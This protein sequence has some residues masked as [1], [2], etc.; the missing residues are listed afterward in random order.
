MHRVH[1]LRDKHPEAAA[2]RAK[3]L[4]AADVQKRKQ[5]MRVQLLQKEIE[6]LPDSVFNILPE[7]EREQPKTPT[8]KKKKPLPG[9]ASDRRSSRGSSQSSSKSHRSREQLRSL[10]TSP[11][12]GMGFPTPTPRSNSVSPGSSPGSTRSHPSSTHTPS[13]V[14]E[15]PGAKLPSPP[16]IAVP[17]P[18]RTAPPLPSPKLP[19]TPTSS[20]AS[21]QATS[22]STSPGQAVRSPSMNLK[23]RRRNRDSRNRTGNPLTTASNVRRTVS[24][25]TS[26]PS[27]NIS[28]VAPSSTSSGGSYQF[29]TVE[30]GTRNRQTR[31]LPTT[32]PPIRGK[33]REMRLSKSTPTANLAFRDDE[34]SDSDVDSI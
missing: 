21:S 23:E 20:K 10:S 32:T 30:T 17:K 18:T 28:P 25:G 4:D 6:S 16:N 31:L 1:A 29:N 2:P 9:V 12:S 11:T 34:S 22:P 13:P 19:P 7:P 15:S 33:L 8:L 14:K 26:L 24:T 27:V 5:K 3:T